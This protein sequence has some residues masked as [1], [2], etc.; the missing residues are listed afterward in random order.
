MDYWIEMHIIVRPYSSVKAPIDNKKKREKGL[1][2]GRFEPNE[3][4]SSSGEEYSLLIK[5]TFDNDSLKRDSQLTNSPKK[6]I[7]ATYYN[8]STCKNEQ[9]P[10][11]TGEE[12]KMDI[13]AE[14]Y[15]LKPSSPL[16]DL[17]YYE[18][19]KIEMMNSGGL[20]PSNNLDNRKEN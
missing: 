17:A 10:L 2:K 18:N 4:S 12:D 11:F 14:E 5:Q 1:F 20:S 9:I 6:I 3:E 19:R 7:N 8:R 13:I 15:D 16:K